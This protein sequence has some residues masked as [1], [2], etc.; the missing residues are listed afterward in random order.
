MLV[1]NNFT[2]NCIHYLVIVAEVFIS[3]E[4]SNLGVSVNSI[5]CYRDKI[6]IHGIDGKQESCLDD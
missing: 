2:D 4:L 1:C 5:N 3:W 6:Y